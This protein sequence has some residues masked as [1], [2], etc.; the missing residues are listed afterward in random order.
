MNG[1]KKQ[2]S[3]RYAALDIF[4]EGSYYKG[5][6]SF[7][8]V[9]TEVI[10]VANYTYVATSYHFYASQAMA[11]EGAPQTPASETHHSVPPLNRY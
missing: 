7:L 1:G 5:A 11:S 2:I 4:E 10:Y 9:N 3:M 8:P 6:L